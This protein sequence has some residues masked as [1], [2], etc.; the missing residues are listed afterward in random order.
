MAQYLGGKHNPESGFE[1]D[2]CIFV[3]KR[4]FAG[5]PRNSY[6]DVVDGVGLIGWLKKHPDVKAIASSRL[7]YEEMKSKLTQ[8]VVF[9]P[10]HHCN[11]ERAVRAD[12]PVRVVG[13]VGGV[14]AIQCDEQELSRLFRRDGLEYVHFLYDNDRKDVARKFMR[15]D[16]QV[17]WRSTYIKASRGEESTM[18][19]LKNCLKLVNAS[20]FGIPTVSLPE[21]S[22]MCEHRND[23]LVARTV[24]ELVERVKWLRD[25]LEL[26]NQYA[27][28]GIQMAERYHISNISKLYLSLCDV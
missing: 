25:D 21:A 12:R 8:E 6:V 26:Y 1:D 18:T 5:Y 10:Q 9:I 27:L 3:K 19:K 13:T 14:G 22:Y 24:P 28:S 16:V 23:F 2:V 15:L 4:P 20:S 11:Y 7:G 17:N